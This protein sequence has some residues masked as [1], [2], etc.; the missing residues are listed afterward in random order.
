MQL[1]ARPPSHCIA[2]SD[3]HLPCRDSLVSGTVGM[4]DVFHALE[5]AE[6]CRLHYWELPRWYARENGP[7]GNLGR[8]G[9]DED[10]KRGLT[11]S[12]A[13]RWFIGFESLVG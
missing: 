7:D 8:A 4:G 11:C 10:G 2:M 5:R 12:L 13:A 1:P 3:R 6:Q 9:G